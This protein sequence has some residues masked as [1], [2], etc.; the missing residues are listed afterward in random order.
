MVSIEEFVAG[1]SFEK[2]RLD[3]KTTSAVIKRLRLLER[4]KEIF[5]NF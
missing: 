5:Q 3:D 1:M 4:Q 2:F